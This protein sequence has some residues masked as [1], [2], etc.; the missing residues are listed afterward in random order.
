MGGYYD[1]APLQSSAGGLVAAV[2]IICLLCCV[3]GVYFGY[4]S[5]N[6]DLQEFKDQTELVGDKVLDACSKGLSNFKQTVDVGMENAGAE[7]LEEYDGGEMVDGV[8][9]VKVVEEVDETEK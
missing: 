5:K 8:E 7:K 6:E 4:K 2:I 3:V 9:V 1:N